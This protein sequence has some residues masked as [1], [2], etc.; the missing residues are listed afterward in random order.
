MPGLIIPIQMYI[1]IT[2]GK[3]AYPRLIS[4]RRWGCAWLPPK[5]SN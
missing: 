2:V 4:T 1:V 3:L 5:E